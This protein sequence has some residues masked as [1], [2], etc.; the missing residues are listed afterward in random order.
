ML[1]HKV[2]DQA[3]NIVKD[4]ADYIRTART[5]LL[6]GEIT[7]KADMSLV[8]TI[9]VGAEQRLV[10]GLGKLVPGVKFLAEEQHK[11]NRSELM[12]IIDPIDGTTNFVHGFPMF[13]I[14][15]ALYRDGKI[16]LGIIYEITSQECFWSHSGIDVV[17]LNQKPVRV[18][19]ART[20]AES[21]LA[22][23]F[24]SRSFDQMDHF[25]EVFKKMMVGTHG[26]RRLGSA[27]MDL[28]YVASGRCD[29]FFEYSLSPWDVAAGAYLVQKAGGRVTDFKGGD[30]FL[31]DG[32]ILASNHWIH[33]EFLKYFE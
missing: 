13:C 21:V 5:Q 8:T 20:I 31:F 19:Q 22:T 24:P 28:A 27:A 14:S 12:W 4:T 33:D 29:G 18:S 3:L 2:A 23:G 17:K 6:Q 25:F 10:S 30:N 15:V 1:I 32:E 9:D 7:Y 26:L 16:E 11:T